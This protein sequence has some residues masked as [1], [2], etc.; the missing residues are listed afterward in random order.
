[1][2]DEYFI[3]LQNP[4]YIISGTLAEIEH[5][6]KV[7]RPTSQVKVEK[8]QKKDEK[9]EMKEVEGYGSMA[10]SMSIA[11]VLI[12]AAAFAAA[13]TI[14]GAYIDKRDVYDTH[15]LNLAFKVFVVMD[16]YAFLC[17]IIAT[18]WLVEAALPFLNPSYRKG[19]LLRCTALVMMA[20]KGFI[21]AFATGAYV[22]LF[23]VCKWLAILVCLS[24]GVIGTVLLQPHH[25]PNLSVLRIVIRYM[26]W[27]GFFGT[28]FLEWGRFYLGTFLY[29]FIVLF[30]LTVSLYRWVYKGSCSPMYYHGSIEYFQ[31]VTLTFTI[32]FLV[33]SSAIPFF[34]Y[35]IASKQIP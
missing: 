35:T 21:I 19:Y 32:L 11:S 22:I 10:N 30:L 7:H 23:P 34:P 16:T 3:L 2:L 26:G 8:I 27:K 18:A 1:M 17:S 25:W 28:T 20:A 12:A 15:C 24:T 9:N 29:V 6:L 5:F 4:D 14:Y 31:V 13:F 33:L